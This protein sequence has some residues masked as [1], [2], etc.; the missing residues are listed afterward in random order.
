VF[1]GI[2]ERGGSISPSDFADFGVETSQAMR[3]QTRALEDATLVESSVDETDKRRRLIEVTARGWIVNYERSGYR[4]PRELAEA[5]AAA[6]PPEVTK[7]EVFPIE[8]G[9]DDQEVLPSE[10]D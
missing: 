4:T 6:P 3:G 8:P 1:E 2:V 7:Q 10:G 5:R 9:S